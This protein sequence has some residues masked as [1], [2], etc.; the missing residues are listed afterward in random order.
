MDASDFAVTHCMRC[1]AGWTRT[2]SNGTKAVFCLLDR[3]PVLT[4]MVSCD[5]FELRED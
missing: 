3:E 4:N 2:I 1:A 5:R